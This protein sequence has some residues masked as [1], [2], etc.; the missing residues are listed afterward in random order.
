MRRSD[1]FV[2]A[3]EPITPALGRLAHLQLGS[4]RLGRQVCSVYGHSN[5]SV[6]G[7]AVGSSTQKRRT[8]LP[9][10]RCLVSEPL[11]SLFAGGNRG[12]LRQILFQACVQMQ[13]RL[14]SQYE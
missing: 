8:I 12:L 4:A 7:S 14:L 10:K 5:A 6:A 9:Q 11:S 13:T 3:P 1:L 2:H